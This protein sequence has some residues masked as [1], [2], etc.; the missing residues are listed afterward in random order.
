MLKKSGLFLI[1]IL[2]MTLT[3]CSKFHRIQKHGTLDQKLE[4]GIAY[5]EKK[6]YYKSATLL[7]EIVPL[8]KGQAKADVALFYLAYDYYM[9]E[10]YPMS[11]F[12]FQEFYQTYHRSDKHEEAMFMYCKSLYKES[13]IF[14]LDQTNTFQCLKAIQSFVNKYPKSLYVL[15]CN[16]MVDDLNSKLERKDYEHAKLYHKIHNYKAAVVAL[17]NF[18]D[19]YPMSQFNE[20]IAYIRI[21]SQ[22]ELAHHSIHGK[23]QLERYY[24]AIGFYRSFIEKFPNSKYATHAKHVSDK[25]EA[26]LTKLKS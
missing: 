15:E 14:N 24:D 25:C 10:Q 1:L 3:S 20:E 9:Q 26:E 21:E 17:T 2:F 19:Q 16:Y 8:L 18:M 13:P 11:T 6:D 23:V 4:A 5:Y 12:Y 7:E 22:Y